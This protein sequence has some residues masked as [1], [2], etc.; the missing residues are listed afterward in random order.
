MRA[1]SR[2]GAVAP[3]RA[4][5][6]APAAAARAWP[7][8][9][10]PARPRFTCARSSS[11]AAIASLTAGALLGP[12]QG[13]IAAH[14]ASTFFGDLG[15]R[16]ASRRAREP[17]LQLAALSSRRR[18]DSKASRP[19][20]VENDNCA[21]LSLSPAG[22]GCAA[23]RRRLDRG[24]HLEGPHGAIASPTRELGRTT[25]AG[26]RCPR[27]ARRHDATAPASGRLRFLRRHSRH[28]PARS[29]LTAWATESDRSSSLAT[30]GTSSEEH[31][32]GQP[33][34]SPPTRPSRRERSTTN[35]NCCPRP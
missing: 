13:R 12:R 16:G 18:N 17:R 27:A 3:V 11:R 22:G 23:I 9:T 21:Q 7:L 5:E 14:A 29:Q 4:R 34:R 10:G 26:L 31:G 6:R 8:R 2:R 25:D 32:R 30:T 15:H 35:P 1:G 20:L 19:S 28:E 33:R 24:A